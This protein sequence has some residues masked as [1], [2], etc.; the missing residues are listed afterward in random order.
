MRVPGLLDLLQ[1]VHVAETDGISI[2]SRMCE[3]IL[4]FQ[5]LS[6]EIKVPWGAHNA[7]I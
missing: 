3:V 4:P 7:S 5:S 2:Q 1:H 6:P